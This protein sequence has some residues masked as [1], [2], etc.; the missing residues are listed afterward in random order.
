MK[1]HRWKIGVDGML[2]FVP[3]F[4][5]LHIF[6]VTWMMKYVDEKRAGPS[7]FQSVVPAHH[8]PSPML[9]TSVFTPVSMPM[10]AQRQSSKA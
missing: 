4:S 2:A 3:P 10:A 7:R 9:R 5:G 6:T 1:S 8:G